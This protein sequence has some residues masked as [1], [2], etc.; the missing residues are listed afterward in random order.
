MKHSFF[1]RQDTAVTLLYSPKSIA[2]A[3]ATARSAL[4][5]GADAIAVELTRIPLEERTEE[6]FR[7]LQFQNFQIILHLN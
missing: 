1:N 5:D 6:K 2:E 4:M 7:Q 3:V